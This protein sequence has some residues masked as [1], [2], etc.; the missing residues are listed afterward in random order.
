MGH[1]VETVGVEGIDRVER[2][3]RSMVEHHRAVIGAEI[4]VRATDETWPMRRAQ[5]EDWLANGDGV[6]LL[7][8]TEAGAEPDGYAC[9][10][11]SVT[12]PTFSLGDR[13]AELES[14]AVA[15]HARGSGIGSLLIAAARERARELG[16]AYWLVSAVD[17]N[18]GAVRLYEREGFRPFERILIA[19]L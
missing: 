1:I 10:R 7:A 14:L 19:N 5:Y 3:W 18:E 4:P 13:V 15:E 6:L 9:V 12:G 16:V 2:L 11:T 17:A 8:V